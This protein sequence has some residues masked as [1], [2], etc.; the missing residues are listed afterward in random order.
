MQYSM[1]SKQDTT[2]SIDWIH[3]VDTINLH[4]RIMKIEKKIMEVLVSFI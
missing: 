1:L 3:I 4:M 2:C